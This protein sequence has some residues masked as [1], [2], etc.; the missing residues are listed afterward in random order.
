MFGTI[1]ITVCVCVC[2]HEWKGVE[3]MYGEAI[4]YSVRIRASN[5]TIYISFVVHAVSVA[6]SQMVK[7][8]DCGPYIPR[9]ES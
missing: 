9:F 5:P 1:L 3:E 6:C 4:N 2:V 7:A 8:L